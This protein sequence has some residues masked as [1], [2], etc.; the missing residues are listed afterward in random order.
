MTRPAGR[1]GA[2][3]AEWRFRFRVVR[4]R[5]LDFL[6][7]ST[8]GPLWRRTLQTQQVYAPGSHGR[9]PR[10]ERDVVFAAASILDADRTELRAYLPL[11]I[12]G[13][14]GESLTLMF[15]FCPACGQVLIS[16]IDYL[17]GGQPPAPCDAQ[18]WPRPRSWKGRKRDAMRRIVVT[19]RR[20]L[21]ATRLMLMLVITYHIVLRAIG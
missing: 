19:Y 14:S 16:A 11:E 13:A 3:A 2:G 7:P 4:A 10:C 6:P 12:E 20:Q 9:C 18:L 17:V 5:S 21:C 8:S 15:A 1:R